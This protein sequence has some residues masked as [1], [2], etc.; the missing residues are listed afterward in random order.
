MSRNL[1][2]LPFELALCVRKQQS[3]GS[4]DPVFRLEVNSVQTTKFLQY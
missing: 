2:G 1:L 3:L 4:N